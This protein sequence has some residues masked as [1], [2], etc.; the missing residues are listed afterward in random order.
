MHKHS[1]MFVSQVSASCLS[2][3]VQN[4]SRIAFLHPD[5]LL[6]HVR[7]SNSSQ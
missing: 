7:V 1:G 3:L 6:S 5:M 2:Q 4:V